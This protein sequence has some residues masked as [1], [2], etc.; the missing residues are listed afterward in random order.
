MIQIVWNMKSAAS[1]PQSSAIANVTWHGYADLPS[2]AGSAQASKS[3]DRM[4]TATS[5]DLVRMQNVIKMWHEWHSMTHD[6]ANHS[7]SQRCCLPQARHLTVCQENSRRVCKISAWFRC[8]SSLLRRNCNVL[9][10]TAILIQFYPGLMSRKK[11]NVSTVALGS[12]LGWIWKIDSDC[13]YVSLGILDIKKVC[14]V[15]VITKRKTRRACSC[16]T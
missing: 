9:Q 1:C 13:R 14:R 6:T 5:F 4:A 7:E 10:C 11:I 3:E 8:K 12:R 15:A 16:S 2:H